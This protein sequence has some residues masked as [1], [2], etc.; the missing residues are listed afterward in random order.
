MTQKTTRR[1]SFTTSPSVRAWRS[2]PAIALA[3]Q[4]RQTVKQDQPTAGIM[5]DVVL[6]KG[7]RKIAA[8]FVPSIEGLTLSTASSNYISTYGL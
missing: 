4:P 2:P 6:L 5:K 8:D 3:F 7:F 1:I